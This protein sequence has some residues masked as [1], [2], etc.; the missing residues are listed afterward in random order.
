MFLLYFLYFF[1]LILRYIGI[2]KYRGFF[3]IGYMCVIIDK[4]FIWV[5]DVSI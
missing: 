1:I 4:L 5:V 2:D 3:Y